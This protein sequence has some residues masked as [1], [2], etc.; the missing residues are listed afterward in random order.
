MVCE[1]VE[2]KLRAAVKTGR[3]PAQGDERIAAALKQRVITT[4]EL[5]LMGEMKSLRRGVIMVDDFP[6]DF[7]PEPGSEAAITP[8]AAPA[9][10]NA[11]AASA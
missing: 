1:A 11:C 7:G 8:D 10:A 9:Q 5:E 2:A 3:I 6:P 4:T